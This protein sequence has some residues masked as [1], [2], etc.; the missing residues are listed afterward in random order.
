MIEVHINTLVYVTYKLQIEFIGIQ[1][2][3]L[4]G[5]NTHMRL[6]RVYF[7]NIFR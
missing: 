7:Y 3:I 1:S 5:N 4:H 2:L 6:T